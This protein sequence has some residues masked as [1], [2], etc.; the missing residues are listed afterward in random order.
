MIIIFAY[1]NKDSE[2]ALLSSQVI[3][4]LGINMRHEA[5]ILC[6]DGTKNSDEIEAELLK[7]FPT[8]HRIIA[9][10]GFN[11]WPLGPNQMFSDA[12][13]WASSRQKSWMFFEADCVAMRRGWVDELQN[14]YDRQGA[15]ILG[16]IV[17]SN[18]AGRSNERL[19]NGAAIY[20][21]DIFDYCPLANGLNAYNIAFRDQNVKPQAWDFYCRWEFMKVGA[22]TPLIRSY[23]RSES[24]RR[25][26]DGKILFDYTT[27]EQ[28]KNDKG[29][30]VSNLAAV[31]H[32]SK[33]VNNGGSLHRLILDG[34]YTPVEFVTP[35][36]A[37]QFVKQ[38]IQI[39]NNSITIKKDELVLPSTPP[40]KNH[41]GKPARKTRKAK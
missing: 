33:D 26:E 18:D 34:I 2:L 19:I 17:T 6:P 28:R 29:C 16:D 11:G 1:C 36:S 32:G 38:L 20:S 12:A 8:V 5:A 35:V 15:A 13:T 7:A 40:S 21:A 31:V 3:S 37:P 39:D 30:I 25:N 24:Y 10:N 14:E 4:S 22:G 23:W 41:R 27:T 9:Q